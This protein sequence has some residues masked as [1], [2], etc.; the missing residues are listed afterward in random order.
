MSALALVMIVRNEERSLRRCL[1]SV[2]PFVDELIILDTG[3]T[4]QTVAIATDMGAKVSHF[5][6]CH[7]FSAARNA[8]LALS[9]ADWNLMLD[10][11]EW[12]MEGAEFLRAE[13]RSSTPFI[14]S[15]H[16]ANSINSSKNPE[17]SMSWAPRLV[18]RGTRF[19]GAIHEQPDSALP[20]RRLALKIAH[21]GYLP[22][23]M[24]KKRERNEVLLR[25]ALTKSPQDPYLLYQSG[26]N[27][28]VYQNYHDAA[29]YY[30]QALL[31][32]APTASYRHDLVVR[33]LF[34][35][36]KAHYLENAIQLADSEMHNW[37]DSPD[38]FFALG[39]V[40]LDWAIQHPDKAESEILPLVEAS[41][42]KCL[43][44][45]ERPELAGTVIGRGSHAAA[46]NLLILYEG[47]GNQREADKYRD[48]VLPAGVPV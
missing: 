20:R 37:Q 17:V 40:F 42:K 16:I 8:A 5:T 28:E 48:M 18:P 10:A 29:E 7:D 34:T 46:L 11:D 26:K 30:T 39:D 22:L 19:H 6:W 32:T 1:Q 35:L 38:F 23:H 41:W 2:T 27:A 44:I 24:E 15:V 13:L 14:G 4:D 33:T 21:D 9:H 47:L 25:Q 45:G 43:E 36:K 3:S 12:I 31:H